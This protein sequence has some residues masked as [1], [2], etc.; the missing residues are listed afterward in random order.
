MFTVLQKPGKLKEK[1]QTEENGITKPKLNT[2]KKMDNYLELYL[3]NSK[4]NS[5]MTN[6]ISGSVLE[7][8]EI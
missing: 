1:P 7:E 2:L 3:M 8:M 5:L 4:S 6:T